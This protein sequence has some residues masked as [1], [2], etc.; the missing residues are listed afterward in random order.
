MKWSR[1]KYKAM[2]KVKNELA[3]RMKEMDKITNSKTLL[4]D[5]AG[6]LEL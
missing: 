3:K 1:N 5:C 2:K 4:D 6:K